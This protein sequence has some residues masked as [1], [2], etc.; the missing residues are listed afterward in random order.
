MNWSLK[1][2]KGLIGVVEVKSNYLLQINVEIYEAFSYPKL[3][4]FVF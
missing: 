2:G 3:F 4:F 1:I